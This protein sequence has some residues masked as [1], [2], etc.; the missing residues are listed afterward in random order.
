MGAEL[1]KETNVSPL[2]KT[3]ESVL[4]V[5]HEQDKL[6]NTVIKKQV[7]LFPQL[8]IL[9]VFVENCRAAADDLK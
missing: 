5:E 6:L 3:S 8:L 9:I 2:L 7:F 4:P 1:L